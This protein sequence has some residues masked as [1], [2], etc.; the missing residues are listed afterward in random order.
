LADKALQH[1]VRVG[2]AGESTVPYTGTNKVCTNPSTPYDAVAWGYVNPASDFPS[3]QQIKAA[4]CT[5][6]PL[7]TRLRVVSNALF[8]YAGGVYNEAVASDSAGGGHAV[9]IVG[10][11]DN[12]GA[13][14]IK[15][16]WGTDWGGDEQGFGWMGYNS[17]RIGRHT[18]W[19][20]AKSRFYVFKPLKLYPIHQ[21]V[22]IGPGPIHRVTPITR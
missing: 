20:R 6:G 9:V 2:N 1:M 14:L 17:N 4:L 18:A 21:P 7:A 8:S 11:D 13:W 5:Y 12:K 3:R 22:P 15:N 10:W 16:S 19:I